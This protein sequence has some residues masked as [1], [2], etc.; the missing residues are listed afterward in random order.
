MYADACAF[1]LGRR[2]G[3]GARATCE[4]A[5]VRVCMWAVEE[6]KRFAARIDDINCRLEELIRSVDDDRACATRWGSLIM[7]LQ[8]PMTQAELSL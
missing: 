3:V 2:S 8:L 5:G 4:E 7:V 1:L 6:W